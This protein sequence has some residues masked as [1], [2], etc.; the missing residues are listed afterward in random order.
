MPVGISR[1]WPGTPR[2]IIE[3]L[4]HARSAPEAGTPKPASGHNAWDPATINIYGHDQTDRHLICE[5]S[6]GIPHMRRPG[7]TSQHH[8]RADQ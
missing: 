5:H 7:R 3:P 8:G 6:C 1:R 2:L 4:A